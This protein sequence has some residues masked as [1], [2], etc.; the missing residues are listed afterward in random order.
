MAS[1]WPT[2]STSAGSRFTTGSFSWIRL[3]T[4]GSGREGAGQL[5]N[6]EM[7]V[8]GLLVGVPDAEDGRLVE[9]PAGDLHGERQPI[10]SE[11]DRHGQHRV[12]QGVPV[13]RE[14]LAEHQGDPVVV[15]KDVVVAG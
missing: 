1:S 11:P 3:K 7:P 15:S 8:G 12:A 10:G 4:T 2:V 9:G 6:L 13:G 14:D 5:R